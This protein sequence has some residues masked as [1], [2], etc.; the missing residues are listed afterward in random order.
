MTLA[1]PRTG[2]AAT[3]RRR[4]TGGLVLGG[5]GLTCFVAVA[6]LGPSPF[7]PA[8]PGGGPPFALDARPSPYLVVALV[9]A[10]LTASA[11]GLALCLRATRA[12]PVRPLLVAGLLTA[13]VL[14]FLPPVGSSDHLNY[15]GYGRMAVTGHDPYATTADDLTGD[16]VAGAAEEW[17]RTPSVYGPVATAGQ[18]VASWIGGDSLRLTVFVLSVMNVL[19]FAGTA[20]LLHRM[21]RDD[22]GRAR[23]ALL[24]TA[25]PLVLYHLVAGAHNDVWAIAPMVAALA[26][27]ARPGRARTLLTGVLVAV[28][29]AVKL[30]AALVGG[31]PAW[32]LLRRRRP[33]GLAALFGAAVVT[34]AVLFALAGPHVFDQTGRAGGM[35]SLATPWHLVRPFLGR[36]VIKY[37]AAA[38]GIALALLLYRGLPVS[39]DVPRDDPRRVAAALLV[40]WLFT[41]PYVLPWYDGYGWALLALLPLSRFDAALLVHTFALSL[42]YLPARKPELIGLPDGLTWLFTTLRPDVIPCVLT[43]AALTVAVL[44][45]RRSPATAAPPPRSAAP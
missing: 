28:G 42:A 9:V 41:A 43:I 7:E 8:L 22:K 11:A 3:A 45:V 1:R 5:T 14:A 37:L 24:W 32:L 27:F 18:A 2:G 29:A 31:G 4:A 44:C 12:V 40:G 10:G 36:D 16:P 30:P 13:A 19:A 26:V 15:A 21:A 33:A 6:V 38:T 23:A 35:I 17:R 39:R 20:L 34:A 25:N